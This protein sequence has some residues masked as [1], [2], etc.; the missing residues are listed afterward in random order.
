MENRRPWESG[1]RDLFRGCLEAK[2]FTGFQC[3]VARC[4][5]RAGVCLGACINISAAPTAEQLMVIDLDV[6]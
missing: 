6:D 3:S 4:Q 5:S 2:Y 1:P